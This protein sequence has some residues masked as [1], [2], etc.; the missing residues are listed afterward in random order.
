[1]KIALLL[2]AAAC[3]SCTVY[4]Q[5]KGP[6]FV[7]IGGRAHIATHTFE[8]A[9]DNTESFRD[10]TRLAGS[11]GLAY[12]AGEVVKAQ[13]ATKAATDKAAIDAGTKG[14]EIEAASEAARLQQEI[15]LR[16]LELEAME[17][18]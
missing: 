8:L 1:M 10:A 7:Q 18:L 13:D 5:P 9:A 3:S 17:A 4:H 2:A 12:I 16:S 6:T 15:D 14:Q 11:L